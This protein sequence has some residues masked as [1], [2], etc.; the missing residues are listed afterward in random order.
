MYGGNTSE[1]HLV[2]GRQLEVWERPGG[3]ISVTPSAVEGYAH[4]GRWVAAFNALVLLADRIPAARREGRTGA[5][6]SRG[7]PALATRRAI[8]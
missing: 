1:T 4:A 8:A 7:A 3:S 6:P 5:A 2:A